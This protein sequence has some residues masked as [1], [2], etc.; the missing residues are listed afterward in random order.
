[1]SEWGSSAS[2][3]NQAYRA[4]LTNLEAL[5]LART[6]QLRNAVLDLERCYDITLEALGDALGLRDV[7]MKAHSQR[8]C[9]FTTAVARAMRVPSL[10]MSVTARGAFLH[11]L[12]MLSVPEAILNKPGTL[13]PDE[14]SRMREHCNAGYRML[15]TIPFLKDAA[16]IVYAHHES[17]DGTGYPR[18]LKGD[19]IP[20]GARIC[21]VAD[22]IDSITSNRPYRVARSLDAVREEI[23]AGSGTQFDPTVVKAYLAVPEHVWQ[24]LRRE[25]EGRKNPPTDSI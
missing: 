17:Y 13:T 20:L 15:Q 4:Y 3:D 11:D 10:E 18:G 22:A 2:P 19:A 6:E 7:E 1:M 16:E 12:G 25:I 5:V 23:R 8:V 14:T 24:D 21:A 9:A